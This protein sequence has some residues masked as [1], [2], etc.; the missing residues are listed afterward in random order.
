M[1][2]LG[3]RPLRNERVEPVQAIEAAKYGVGL[4]VS[5][6][7][8]RGQMFPFDLVVSLQQPIVSGYGKVEGVPVYVTNGAGFWGPRS[9][10]ARRHR[11]GGVE[12]L[13][14]PARQGSLGLP[15]TRGDGSHG[16]GLRAWRTK[17]GGVLR[18][19]VRLGTTS[20][21]R[22]ASRL[23]KRWAE[24]RATAWR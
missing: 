23:R 11:N 10:S 13:A 7:T 3:L 5:G 22:W 4:Q 12:A 8:H 1:A 20:S 2:S 14:Y 21:K 9:G 19:M 18:Q 15:V 24:L 6:H 17:A 16:R